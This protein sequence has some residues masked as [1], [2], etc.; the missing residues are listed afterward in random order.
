MS[1]RRRHAILSGAI[2]L[3]LFCAACGGG[4]RGPQTSSTSRGFVPVPTMS[5]TRA[6][7]ET[8]TSQATA[9]SSPT[10]TP[11]GTPNVQA[12]AQ[13]NGC[14][15]TPFAS[16]GPPQVDERFFPQWYGQGNL[17]L[18]PVSIYALMY[19]GT[20]SQHLA[21]ASV[22]FQ[23]ITPALVLANA[24]PT[25]IGH[26]QGDPSTTLSTSP[27][28][29]DMYGPVASQEP[30]HAI[31]INLPETGC[32]QLTI[33]SGTQSL[34][35]TLWAVPLDQR[36]DVV[37]LRAARTQLT[38]YTPP[39]TCQVTTWN[40][41]ADHQPVTSADYWITGQGISIDSILPVYFV[42]QSSYLDIYHAFKTQPTL[43][44]TLTGNAAAAVRSSWILYSSEAASNGWRGEITFSD[45]GCWQLQVT[46]GSAKVPFIL[47]VFPADCYHGLWTPTPTTCEP[48]T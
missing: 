42:S 12:S 47:Y 10:P 20:A 7:G 44:G 2:V 39:S 35:V 9:I 22:W 36:P 46:D 41:P 19:S 13:A 32:W 11:V 1:G 3:A 24:T 21:K 33:T 17:W 25:V 34:N 18:A 26:L 28:S 14:T 23:G 48:P 29:A 4:G 40:G 5:T 15:I 37:V 8:E 27:A 30:V 43:T 38:P 16:N 6:A 45:P 31:T